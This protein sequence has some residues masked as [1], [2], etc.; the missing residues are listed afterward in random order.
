MEY[1]SHRNLIDFMIGLIKGVGKYYHEE[2]QI[3]KLAANRVRIVFPLL[4][5]HTINKSDD[6]ESQTSEAFKISEV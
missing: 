1:K 6:F 5:H 2:L 4:V 3:T